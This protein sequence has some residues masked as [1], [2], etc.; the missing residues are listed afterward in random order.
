M[1]EGLLVLPPRLRI[2]SAE[3]GKAKATRG[4]KAPAD[5]KAM[6]RQGRMTNSF[7]RF[8]K[9]EILRKA[10]NDK[11]QDCFV[12]RNDMRFFGVTQNDKYLFL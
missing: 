10:Q 1:F 5:A 7:D 2:A 12:P 9:Y 11:T 4:R 8:R 6:A 3:R